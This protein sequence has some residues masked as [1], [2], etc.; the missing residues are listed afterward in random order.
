MTNKFEIVTTDIFDQYYKWYGYPEFTRKVLQRC[1][2]KKDYGLVNKITLVD[3]EPS[4]RIYLENDNGDDFTIRYNICSQNEK[5]W[6]ANY[7]LYKTVW[8][9]DGSGHGEE[10]SEGVAVT[11]YIIDEKE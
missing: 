10:I 1:T 8:H 5:Q 3:A 9:E 7:T 11:S 6:R 2:N 4:K